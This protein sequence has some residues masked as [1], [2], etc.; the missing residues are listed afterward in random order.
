MRFFLYLKKILFATVYLLLAF[1]GFYAC[2]SIGSPG[3]GDYDVEPPV[4]IKSDPA[5]SSINF[6]KNKITLWFDEYLTIEKP[7]EK[8]IITPPQLKAPVISAV[9]KKIDIELR[10]SLIQNTTYTLDFTDGIKD[11]NEGNA[12]EGFTFAFSTGDIIDTL[13]ISGLL[14]NAE[15]LEPMPK[16]IIGIHSDLSDT[17]FTSKPFTRTSITNDRGRFSIRNVAPGTYRIF[18]L[19]D[20]NR[21]FKYSQAGEAIAFHDS[22]IIP[23]FVPSI[24]TDT[25]WRDSLTIDIIKQVE[26]TRFLPDDITLHLF[27]EK[28]D[29]QYLVK[30]ERTDSSRFFMEFNSSTGT[31]PS[32]SLLNKY[33]NDDWYV[34]EQSPDKKIMTYWIADSLIYQTDTLLIKADYLEHDTL[35][36]L[37]EKSDTIKLFQRRKTKND[38]KEKPEFLQTSVSVSGS[39]DINDTI[40]FT[41]SEP[42]A[43]DSETITI[44]QKVDTLWQ[45]VS[46]P[47]VRD[48]LSPLIYYVDYK[49]P[50]RKEYQIT[51]DSAAVHSIY[52]KHNDLIKTIFR[53]L[54]EED[55]GHVYVQ[56]NGSDGKGFG[57]L[58][59][60]TEKVMRE[61]KVIN[62]ELV[63]ENIKPGTYYLRYIDD[64]NQNDEWDPGNYKENIQPEKVYYY[65]GYF[66]VKKYVEFE[67]TWDIASKN[68]KP[69]EITKNKPTEKKPKNDKN[70]NRQTNNNSRR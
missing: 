11:N 47:I 3:G 37:I 21:D 46:L 18:A 67:Q 16:V 15:N 56:L 2:A 22:L 25:I 57:Q 6:N 27:E 14:L 43:F 64:Q 10:D 49:F 42:I 45:K 52:G 31:P 30:S 50:F 69:I 41:F 33:T 7:S 12:I 63:F 13:E 68:Q 19:N 44:E 61:S 48:S 34:L 55:Y 20:L 39:M 53:T 1:C 60:S 62:G 32:I 59:N 4:F 26:Y 51:I 29:M 8:V 35:K 23:S 36:N 24:R 40:K 58:L 9:G 17:A 5:P 70:E 28:Q 54:A 38:N 66:D 65:P